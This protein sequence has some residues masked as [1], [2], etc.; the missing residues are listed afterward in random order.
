MA[1]NLESDQADPLDLYILVI[2]F[3]S[4]E[5]WTDLKLIRSMGL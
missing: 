5:A 1:R 3:A 2:A 4:R